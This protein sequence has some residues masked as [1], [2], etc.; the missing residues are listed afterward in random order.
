MATLLVPSAEAHLPAAAPHVACGPEPAILAALHDPAINLVVWERTLGDDLRA[1]LAAVDLGRVQDVRLALPVCGLQAGLPPALAAAGW[2]APALAADVADLAQRFAGVMAC[3]AVE[4]RLDMVRGD[5]C[6]K[7]HA[8]YVSARL[9]T[10]YLGP[11]TD[12]LPDDSRDETPARRLA[13]GAV[14]L[15]KGRTWPTERPIIHRSPPI[16][17]TGQVRVVLVIN[18]AEDGT[19]AGTGC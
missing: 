10:T 11:G 3:A 17:G 8:D 18:P 7:F 15:F 5:A 12:W 9:V 1:A 4:I 16:A 6:R 2:H 13:A 14:G 19:H